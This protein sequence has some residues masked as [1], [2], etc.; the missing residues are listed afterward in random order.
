MVDNHLSEKLLHFSGLFSITFIKRV[1]ALGKQ[2][3]DGSTVVVAIVVVVVVGG[4]VVIVM[5]VSSIA[6]HIAM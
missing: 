2:E 6:G 1:E 4:T 5:S 3:T